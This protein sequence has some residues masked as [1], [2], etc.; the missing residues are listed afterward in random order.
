MDAQ[1]QGI[2]DCDEPWTRTYTNIGGADMDDNIIVQV[3][4]MISNS[5]FCTEKTCIVET[6]FVKRAAEMTLRNADV[7]GTKWC[8]GL[9]SDDS[10]CDYV[11]DETAQNAG[12]M[13]FDREAECP[14]GP[15]ATSEKECCG[16]YPTRFP[17]KTET[18]ECCDGTDTKPIG[19][20]P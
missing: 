20:C 6:F 12:S 16:N 18:R 8:G 1:E 2:S 10:S 14:R 4:N 13:P 7:G 5:D 9:N 19:N 17:Y 15:G 11:H 3:C